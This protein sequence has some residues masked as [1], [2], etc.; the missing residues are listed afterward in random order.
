[1]LCGPDQYIDRLIRRETHTRF[2]AFLSTGLNVR[3]APLTDMRV[4]VL[5]LSSD[6]CIDGFDDAVPSLYV[7]KRTLH[8]T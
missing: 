8:L 4:F 2:G 3:P 5:Y 7:V 1:M 6:D